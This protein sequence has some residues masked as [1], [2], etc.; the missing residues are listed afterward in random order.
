M[1]SGAPYE[2]PAYLLK[3][4]KHLTRCPMAIAGAD[5]EVVLK[6]ARKATENG[7]ITP[8][9]I[10]N[11]DLIQELS[12]GIGWNIAEFE[13]VNLVREEAISEAA[14]SLAA[15]SVVKGIMKG[16]VHTDTLMRFVIKKDTG[17]RT[18]RRISHI[19]H[20]TV[21]GCDKVLLIT[22]G[23][24]NV[25]PN[26]DTRMD[27]IRNA[28]DVSHALGN[29]APRVAVL[30]GTEVANPSM[31]SSLESAEIVLSLIHI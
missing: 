15:S 14:G 22:D 30:S 9:L 11:A 24:I 2:V 4:A 3:K 1:L 25:A 7:I 17:L 23:A 19:F 16:H 10:G 31:P 27:I 20:L 21:P 12:N 13:I 18:G 29:P 8:I 5:N 26:V 28:I 6:S